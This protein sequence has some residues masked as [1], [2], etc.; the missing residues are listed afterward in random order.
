MHVFAFSYPQVNM[1]FAGNDAKVGPIVYASNF[2]ACTWFNS[3]SPFFKSNLTQGWSFMDI[4][5][6][7]LLRNGVRVRSD[8]FFQTPIQRLRLSSPQD[9][10]V[11]VSGHTTCYCY[12]W[13]YVY[14]LFTLGIPWRFN[15]TGC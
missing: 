7:Y 9:S 10:M 2:S 5:D 14:I 13:L 1:V 3:S 15:S 8:F 4:R 11:V 6:N 12:V